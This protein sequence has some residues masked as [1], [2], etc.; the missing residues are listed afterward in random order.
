MR[1]VILQEFVSIDG[2]A[3]GHDGSVNFVPAATAGDQSFG[4]RQLAFIDSVD[5]IV[6]GRVTYE[7]FAKHWPNVT[8]GDDKPFAEKLNALPKIV[9]SRTLE[10]APW[11][12]FDEATIVRENAPEAMAKLKQKPGKDIVIWGSLTLAQSLMNERL[13]DEYQLIICPTLMPDGV[14]LFHAE[15]KKL[16]LRL[17]ITKSFDHGTVLLS[18]TPAQ[19][20]RKRRAVP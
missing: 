19:P 7:M 11:G 1:T 13:I 9:F 10:R 8:S 12:A 16:D 14:P 17:L 5:T 6:L 18:Y 15:A 2:M 4:R 20:P 3:A